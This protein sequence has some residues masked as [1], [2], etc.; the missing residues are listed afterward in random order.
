M[1]AYMIEIQNQNLL[2]FL[3]L[4]LTSLSQVARLNAVYIFIL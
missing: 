1:I 4:N 3:S 2:I